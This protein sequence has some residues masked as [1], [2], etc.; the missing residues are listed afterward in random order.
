MHQQRLSGGAPCGGLL[1]SSRQTGRNRHRLL[2]ARL[3]LLS[4]LLAWRHHQQRLVAGLQITDI[5]P[6][7][8]VAP[9][10]GCGMGLDIKPERQADFIGGYDNAVTLPLLQDDIAF[11][12]VV[13]RQRGET[14]ALPPHALTFLIR[15]SCSAA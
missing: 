5:D 13:L 11:V 4:T 9:R 12:V 14:T 10:A 3:A 6:G 1:Q 7:D 8:L 2:T 15:S